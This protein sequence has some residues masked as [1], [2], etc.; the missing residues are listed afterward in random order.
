LPRCQSDRVHV[1]AWMWCWHPFRTVRSWCVHRTDR[2]L[3]TPSLKITCTEKRRQCVKRTHRTS[4]SSLQPQ[5]LRYAVC[6]ERDVVQTRKHENPKRFR[7]IWRPLLLTRE[8]ELEKTS[9]Q[10]VLTPYPCVYRVPLVDLCLCH[11]SDSDGR[12]PYTTYLDT[13]RKDFT[14]EKCISPYNT[15]LPRKT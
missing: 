5:T 15:E 13:A 6:R 3:N 1:E 9:S 12:P 10:H 2:V 7:N 14:I 4:K 8:D 11:H